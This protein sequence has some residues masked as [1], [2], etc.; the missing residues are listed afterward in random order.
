VLASVEEIYADE[1]ILKELIWILLK[2]Y[3]F[4]PQVGK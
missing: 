4:C 1:A 3:L 2:V